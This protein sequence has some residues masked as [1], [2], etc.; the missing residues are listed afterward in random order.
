MEIS[1][2]SADLQKQWTF[3]R[4]VLHCERAACLSKHDTMALRYPEQC[5]TWLSHSAAFA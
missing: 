5:E 1:V 4:H 2:V 3:L